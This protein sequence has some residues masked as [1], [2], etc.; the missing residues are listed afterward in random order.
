MKAQM[1]SA[2]IGCVLVILVGIVAA[3]YIIWSHYG[4]RQRLQKDITHL[5][6]TLQQRPVL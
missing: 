3:G 2:V 5:E 4:E 6:N 1:G